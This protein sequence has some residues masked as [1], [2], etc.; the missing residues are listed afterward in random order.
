MKKTI[1]NSLLLIIIF[2][3]SITSNAQVN[4]KNKYRK[5]NKKVYVKKHNNRKG[6]IVKRNRNRIVVK[7]PTR[8]R[9]IIKRPAKTKRGYI[10]ISGHTWHIF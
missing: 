7:K 5:A 10:W 4:V 6:V 1:F 8:P 2:L 9:V 3:I